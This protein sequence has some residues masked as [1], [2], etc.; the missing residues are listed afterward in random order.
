MTDKN[1]SLLI[2]LVYGLVFVLLLAGVLLFTDVLEG[3]EGNELIG[4]GT[5]APDGEPAAA[6]EVRVEV[7]D[8]TEYEESRQA[9]QEALAQ[10]E[11]DR[12]PWNAVVPPKGP[13]G[14]EYPNAPLPVYTSY[15][16]KDFVTEEGESDTITRTW[17]GGWGSSGWVWCYRLFIQGKGQ[18]FCCFVRVLS[19][20]CFRI[21]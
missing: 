6:E 16:G 5:Q 4:L 1:R 12:F 19:C 15:T 13:E 9:Y 18:K 3:G 10:R 14:G 17:I 8:F 11:E 2:G 21:E 20:S 7:Y